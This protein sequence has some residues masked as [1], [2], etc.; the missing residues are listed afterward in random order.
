[1]GYADFVVACND[2]PSPMDRKAIQDNWYLLKCDRHTSCMPWAPGPYTRVAFGP[3]MG[4]SEMSGVCGVTWTNRYMLC[5]WCAHQMGLPKS[6]AKS[7]DYFTKY[8]GRE[9]ITSSDNPWCFQSE[10][11]GQV[12]KE[13]FESE[14]DGMRADESDSQD[15]D[16][17]K[18]AD[19]DLKAAFHQMTRM[20]DELKAAMESGFN[21]MEAKQINL[22]RKLQ[23]KGVISVDIDQDCKYACSESSWYAPDDA[24]PYDTPPGL[25]DAKV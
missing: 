1:M 13:M 8:W 21:G 18:A 10:H 17:S 22:E 14:A 19:K 3:N 24:V 9:L 25:E 23:R 20:M 5:P 11:R 12:F 4:K 15:D 16:D 7:A 6:T 2:V